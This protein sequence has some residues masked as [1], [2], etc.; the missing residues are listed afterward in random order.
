MIGVWHL[1]YEHSYDDIRILEKECRTL[2]QN[3]EYRVT[4]ITSNKASGSKSADVNERYGVKIKILPLKKKRFIRLIH[5]LYDLNREIKRNQ[6]N[7]DV[8]HIHEFCLWLL[9]PF[10]KRRAIKV[11]LDL[12]EDDVNNYLRNISGKNCKSIQ[13]IIKLGLSFYEKT[14]VKK[15]DGVITV[16]PYLTRRIE[17]YTKL[18][19]LI[20]NFPRISNMKRDLRK[21][22][23]YKQYV[24]V[25]CFA[26]GIVPTWSQKNILSAIKELKVKYI[27]AGFSEEAY[28]NQL[29]SM[30][31]WDNQVEFL[32][33][34]SHEEVFDMYERAGI[35]VALL[36]KA[37]IGPEM[38][39]EGTLG[40]T[41]LF[42]FMQ[43]GLPVI[44]TNVTIW[45]KIVD[46][47]RCGIAVDPEK[48]DD[49][50][51]AINYLIAN[52]QLAYEMGRQGYQAVL[53]KYNWE[54]DEKKLLHLYDCVLTGK[55]QI[56]DDI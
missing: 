4:Y 22:D 53:E 20:P 16:T 8:C 17:S 11:I 40:N 46:E 27:L 23:E 14:Y 33:K 7:I 42:E 44:C 13:K 48:P 12:H 19:V 39:E 38:R 43:N 26:G 25:L 54:E 1:G 49:L 51:E 24:N 35:G 30:K 2:A 3:Q 36:N 6:S 55:E 32:G 29:R 34:I 47:N 52:P 56:A 18:Q 21:Y 45:K 28:I 31:A 41:K 37:A 50:K 10:I 5:Y 9:V 15:A